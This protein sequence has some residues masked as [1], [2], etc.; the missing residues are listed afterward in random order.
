MILNTDSQVLMR[1]KE[2]KK[3]ERRKI[4]KKCELPG[5]QNCHLCYIYKPVISLKRYF[6]KKFAQTLVVMTFILAVGYNNMLHIY[7]GAAPYHM[8]RHM[9]SQPIYGR[10]ITGC[11]KQA[12][13]L[14]PNF[15]YCVF[16]C[17]FH[18]LRKIDD[19]NAQEMQKF[20]V[21]NKNTTSTIAS[22]IVRLFISECL[23]AV[24]S[25]DDIWTVSLSYPRVKVPQRQPQRLSIMR[26]VV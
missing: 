26:S 16:A 3:E 19:V 23:S 22:S 11:R 12:S 25:C 10:G 8:Q 18:F 4:K 17:Y 15:K 13:I 9:T 21:A 24:G 20:R 6:K 2:G 7:S 5:L 14:N 1:K